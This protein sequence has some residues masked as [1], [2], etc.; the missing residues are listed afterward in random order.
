MGTILIVEDDDDLRELF[1]E[2]LRNEA[3]SVV[4]ASN[5][6]EALAVLEKV[7]PCLMLLDMMMPVM[8]GGELLETLDR[9]K[10]LNAL[11]IVVVSAIAEQTEAPGACRYM[12]KPIE[13]GALLE[14]AREFCRPESRERDAC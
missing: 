5:G 8:S 3:H 11:S 9:S 10:R 12:Q 7:Q 1:A 6:Q 4:C 2:V 14:V 13:L